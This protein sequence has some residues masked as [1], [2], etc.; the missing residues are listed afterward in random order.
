MLM[1]GARYSSYQSCSVACLS[2][3]ARHA[4]QDGPRLGVAAHLD[5]LVR[6]DHADQRQKFPGHAT[7]HQQ[8]LAGIAGAV[9]LGL[10]VVGDLH[11]H[12]DVAGI[13]DVDMAIAV[14]VLDH[15]NPGLAAD[16]LDQALA[17]A[18]ND[19]VD[20]LRH[21]DQ[22]GDR[23]AIDGLHQLHGLRGQAGLRQRLL[24]QPRQ[25]LVGGDRFRT[26]AQDAGI[27]ALDRQAGGLDGHV[28]TAFV[29]HAEHADRHSHLPDANA[30]GLLLQADDL[31]HDV[32]HRGQLIA[33]Q[34]HRLDD[35]RRE[36]EPVDHGRRKSRRDGPLEV[37]G[38]V[39]LAGP[40]RWR[41][42]V[43]RG[44][45][46]LCSGWRYRNAPSRR[47]PAAR[48]GPAF[49]CTRQRSARS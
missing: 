3:G 18:R 19:Q 13:V 42:A 34:R 31:A 41:A 21:G 5:A 12:L 49:A 20:E 28:G 16:A 24:H 30:A 9:L 45:A 35:R 32:G 40:G 27:A 8:A 10:G 17:A 46:G 22:L 7:C 11:R 23:L 39:A 2:V 47:K 1:M 25:G 44:H 14:Q 29:D 33:S 43:P 15:R 37:V 36:F 26:A 4:G 6:I 48:A 38:V